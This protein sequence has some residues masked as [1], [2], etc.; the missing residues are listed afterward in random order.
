MAKREFTAVATITTLASV[1]AS[2]AATTLLALSPLAAS[3]SMALSS[4]PIAAM[5]AVN[6]GALPL[7]ALSTE[8]L[9]YEVCS[10]FDITQGL[11]QN[12]GSLQSLFNPG[13]DLDLTTTTDFEDLAAP[14]ADIVEF[15]DQDRALAADYVSSAVLWNGA[16]GGLIG[17]TLYAV[18]SPDLW[19]GVF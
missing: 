7:G 13:A 15:T 11:A 6:S 14:A 18:L 9:G 2:A 5:S 17:A 19:R 4:A 12:R 1:F 10:L 8:G 3:N 16:M